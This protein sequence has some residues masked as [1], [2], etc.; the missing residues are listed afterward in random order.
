MR[1]KRH[2]FRPGVRTI[3]PLGVGTALWG[4]GIPARRCLLPGLGPGH[5]PGRAWRLGGRSVQRQGHVEPELA[6]VVAAAQLGRKRLRSAGGRECKSEARRQRAAIGG[7]WRHRAHLPPLCRPL[8]PS[9]APLP[10]F[11]AL[12]RPLPPSAAP[13]L[14]WAGLPPYITPMR[15]TTWAE[16]GL[17]VSL[18]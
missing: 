16:Y 7:K 14:G 8:P 3:G 13:G 15:V 9:A 11:A 4:G 2:P 12:C 5:R 6:P 1:G 17:I 10:P 18:N